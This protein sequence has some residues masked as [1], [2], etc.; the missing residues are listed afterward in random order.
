MKR[1]NHYIR[2]SLGFTL[3]EVLI[4]SLI[5]V[6]SLVTAMNVYQGAMQNSQSASQTL[7]F[8]Q[9]VLLLRTQITEQ[10]RNHSSSGQQRL[11][12]TFQYAEMNVQWQ[13]RL[14]ATGVPFH[15]DNL[16][17]DTITQTGQ[18]APQAATP[19]FLWQVTMQLNYENKHQDYEFWE[20]SW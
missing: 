2:S 8:N 18:N 10:I 9:Y 14:A 12:N 4:A 20:I 15:P 1:N 13:A 7:Y 11:E 19:V 5:L 6:L 17:I 16:P 3:I